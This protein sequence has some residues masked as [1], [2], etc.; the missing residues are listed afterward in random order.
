V[1]RLTACLKASSPG[2]LTGCD[3]LTRH[4]PQAYL[5]RFRSPQPAQAAS[6]ADCEQ[7]LRAAHYPR[8]AVK[9]QALCEQFHRHQLQVAPGVARAKQRLMLTL[10]AQLQ[11]MGEQIAGYDQATGELRAQHVDS[12]LFA[13]LPGAGR[14]FAPRLLAE[15]GDDRS[16]YGSAA[17]VQSLTGTAPVLL[18]S[19]TW[20]RVQVASAHRLRQVLAPVAVSSGA[21][22]RAV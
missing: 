9:A 20:R 11:L 10:L 16:R 13:S 22:K 4:V 21:G 19:G 7:V 3:G 14:R 12:T 5:A 8:P 18:H 6:Q 17:S 2:A 1:N 15:W